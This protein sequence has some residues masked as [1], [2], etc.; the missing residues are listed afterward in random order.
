MPYNDLREFLEKLDA[1]SELA[2][3]E[4]QVDWDAE[5]GAISRRALDLKAQTPHFVN[6]KGYPRGY[7]VL[8]NLLGPTKPTIQGRVALAMDLPKTTPTAKIIEAYAERISRSI[9]PRL[10][11]TGPCKENIQRGDEI[12]LFQFPTPRGH[13]TDGGRYLGAWHICVTRDPDSGWVNWGMYRMMIESKNTL[14]W[15]ANPGQHGP[16]IY[17]QKYEARGQAMPM[18]VAIG[19]EPVSHI[20]AASQFP[21]NVD[22]VDK[23]GALRGAP[24]EVV[25]CETNDLEVPAGSEIVL[26]GEIRP[27]ERE[28]EGPFG[29]YTGYCAGERMPRPVFHVNCVTYRDNPILTIVTPGKPWDGDSPMHTITDSATLTNE[30]RAMGLRFKSVYVMPTKTTICISVSPPYP[31][32]VHT[33]ASAVWATKT[34]L[35]KPYIILVGEDV[36]VTNTDDVLWCL[37]S[38]LH[39][40][41]D[42]HVQQYAPISVLMPFIS[43]AERETLLGARVAFDATFPVEWP[44][45]HTPTVVDLEHSW[46]ADVVQ[47]MLARWEEYGIH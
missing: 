40:A 20:V 28:L 17:Y 19:A 44:K 39:P 23:A 35:Y 3:V 24:V 38:R 31:G 16:S 36:D 2:R 45:E 5:I 8:T 13:G 15:L 25:K 46:P 34:G 4:A 1:E 22:E 26:E 47:K 37:T 6:V 32:Y 33:V 41:R 10:V 9:K 12:D 21:P 11:P 18:A 43:R 14:G 29:E 7:S 42:I 27:Y 30:L